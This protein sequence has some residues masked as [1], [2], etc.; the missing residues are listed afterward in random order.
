MWQLDSCSC[1]V[2]G[3]IFS[4]CKFSLSLVFRYFPRLHAGSLSSG[5]LL[6]NCTGPTELKTHLLWTCSVLSVLMLVSFPPPRYPEWLSAPPLPRPEAGHLCAR[7]SLPSF[8]LFCAFILCLESLTHL[9]H[10]GHFVFKP[11]LMSL[12]FLLLS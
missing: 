2:T 6:G 10:R 3:L 9:C 7:T 1:V 4:P 12:G 11:L 8:P 5:C